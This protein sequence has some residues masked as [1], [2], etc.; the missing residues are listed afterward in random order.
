MVQM[1]RNKWP[2][3]RIY[4]EPR[5]AGHRDRKMFIESAMT[6]GWRLRIISAS[7]RCARCDRHSSKAARATFEFRFAKFTACPHDIYDV[8]PIKIMQESARA[9]D[10]KK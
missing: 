6:D 4:S 9:Y 1:P 2:F 7:S 3:G 8:S 5:E 10:D